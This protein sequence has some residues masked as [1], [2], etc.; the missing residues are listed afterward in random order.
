[1]SNGQRGE[2]HPHTWEFCLNIRVGRS[3][4]TAFHTFE[5]AV[6]RYLSKYQNR[7]LNEVEP[8]NEIIP[9]LEYMTD[10]FAKDLHDI[11]DALGC[12]LIRVAGSESPTRTYILSLEDL[13]DEVSQQAEEQ[14]LAQVVDSVLDDILCK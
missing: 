4:F 10:F 14:I 2:V 8:F 1:V 13:E 5:N 11:I 9:T 6:N 3:S 12:H 7:T